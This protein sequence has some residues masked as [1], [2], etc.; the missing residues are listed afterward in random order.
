MRNIL[1]SAITIIVLKGNENL[2][3]NYKKNNFKIN[4]E[5]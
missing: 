4:E 5:Y 2:S 1:I 3:I